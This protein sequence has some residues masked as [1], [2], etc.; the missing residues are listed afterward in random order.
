M[1]I[2]LLRAG[3][4]VLAVA[5]WAARGGRN[6]DYLVCVNRAQG[7]R[8]E[9]ELYPREL[10]RRLPRIGIPLANGDPDVVLDLQAVL[11]KTHE[12]G[13]YRD[14]LRYEQPC[15]PPLSTENQA[16]AEACFFAGP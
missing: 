14:R 3:Q 6:Y 8:S 16:W 15:V 4:H 9:Y 12:A 2:D 13:R 1:E 7:M 10:S 11:A 5:E